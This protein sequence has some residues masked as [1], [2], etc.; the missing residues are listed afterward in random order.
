[1]KSNIKIVSP[2]KWLVSSSRS[3]A[4]RFSNIFLTLPTNIFKPHIVNFFSS[5]KSSRTESG[6]FADNTSHRKGMS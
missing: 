2:S 6:G 5:F 4:Q 3:E 1:M